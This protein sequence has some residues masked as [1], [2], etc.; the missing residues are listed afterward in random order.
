MQHPRFR[1]ATGR[2]VTAPL[3]CM[4]EHLRRQGRDLHRSRRCQSPSPHAAGAHQRSRP[5]S[6]T[7]NP[8]SPR[9]HVSV[10][11]PS[12][13]A[14]VRQLPVHAPARRRLGAA[15]PVHAPA[16]RRPGAAVAR[17]TPSSPRCPRA[18]A[19]SGS[20]GP[21]CLGG[22]CQFTPRP[23]SPRCGLVSG[24]PPLSSTRT[25]GPVPHHPERSR[26]P[27]AP[28]PGQYLYAS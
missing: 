13:A 2:V 6:I 19:V 23:A 21:R 24:R 27:L 3:W 25:H 1:P 12:T 26:L 14:Q 10:H 28:P 22:S 17:F 8:A 7:A 15:V 18:V 20:P 5:V 11:G 16:R 9:A 4:F